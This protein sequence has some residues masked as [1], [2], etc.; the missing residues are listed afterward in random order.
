MSADLDPEQLDRYARHVV[1]EEVGPEGQARLL[2]SSV[3]VVGAGGLGS[4]AVAA[5]AAAGV[6]RL[7]IADGDVVERSNLQRQTLYRERDVGRPKARRAAEFVRERNPDVAVDVHDHL[8]RETADLVAEYDLVL[9]C[10]DDFPTRYLLNDACVL[11]D[12]PLVHGAVDRFE[13]QATTIAPGGVP[14]DGPGG[15]APADDPETGAT[16]A[17]RGRERGPC[18][19][20]LFPEAPDPGTVPSCAEAGVL[21][22]VPGLVGQLQATEALSLALGRGGSLVG[23]L[24]LY[25]ARGLAVDSVP[26]RPAPDCPVCGTDP[27]IDSVRAVEYEG[28]CSVPES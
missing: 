6:G 27:A 26:A 4:P 17:A 12:R 24:L 25:D 23:R 18:Y 22:V 7:G 16:D 14:V 20:C 13:G 5:L 21:G 8:T 28:R 11:A 3:L 10:T 19:R 15:G 9:D 1:L 2:D